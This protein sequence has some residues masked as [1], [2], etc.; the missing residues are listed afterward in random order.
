MSENDV[1]SFSSLMLAVCL[2]SY[3]ILKISRVLVALNT[4][5]YLRKREDTPS[6]IRT[7]DPLLRRQMPTHLQALMGI[8]LNKYENDANTAICLINKGYCCLLS[9]QLCSYLP[10]T[11]I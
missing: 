2:W 8:L 11:I 4:W 9:F 5:I 3:D 6:R 7:C 10:L 1:S